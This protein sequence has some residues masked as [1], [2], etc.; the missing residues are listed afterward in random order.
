LAGEAEREK[1]KVVRKGEGRTR[2]DQTH[3]VVSQVRACPVEV[4]VQACRRGR[5]EVLGR[6][7][8]KTNGES[9]QSSESRRVA[10]KEGKT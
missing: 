4:V 5:G 9:S 8:N 2:K 3:V 10:I 6:A 7:Q 1:K